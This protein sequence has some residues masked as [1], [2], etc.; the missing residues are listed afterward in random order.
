MDHIVII[1]N[2][3]AGITAARHIRKASKHKITV[4]S[5]ESEHFFSRTALMYIYMGHM[6]YEHTKPYEDSF[7]RKNH[8][9]LVF[10]WV[11]NID[12]TAKTVHF[13]KDSNAPIIYDKL[14]LALGSKPHFYG[15]PGQGLDGVQGLYSLQ[16]LH[17]LEDRSANTKHAVIVGGGLI[18]IELAEMLH[19]RHIPVTF[20][21]RENSFWNNVLPQEESAMIN[22]EIRAHG[23]DLRLGT[24]LKEI[25][26]NDEEGV[27][28]VVTDANESIA[29]QLV[30]IT[31]GVTANI[32]LIKGT[33]IEMER[34]ILV[35]ECLATSVTDVY[36]IGDCAQ[37]R[38]PLP[39]RRAIEQVWYTGRMM[40][41]T[42]ARTIAGQPTKYKPGVWFNSAKFFNLEYQTYGHVPPANDNDTGS[43]CWQHA[44]RKKMVRVNYNTKT[45]VVMGVNTMGI[46]MRHE[47]WDTWISQGLKLRE[48]MD[49]LKQAMFDPEFYQ[50]HTA[51]IV[52]T[53]NATFPNDTV[54]IRRDKSVFKQLLG[55]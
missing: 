40:G 39:H 3:I 47:V 9:D 29:C 10:G 6:T 23:I 24:G 53:Y 32:D 5:G 11:K 28:S 1:G 35:D 12:F 34:G 37:L 51:E 4:I 31:T 44:D 16:D 42:V 46:R 17:R 21:V 48:V 33:A 55:L 2:G 27:T 14:I 20:L 36:A 8:I 49:N 13:D 38:Q 19:S 30:G 15:W 7:W 18:G 41:E 45:L 25:N 22:E 54:Q 26:G 50:D 43:I 52:S